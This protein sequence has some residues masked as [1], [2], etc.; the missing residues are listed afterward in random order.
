MSSVPVLELVPVRV[1]VRVR[2]V[3]ALGVVRRC[4]GKG[5]G[6]RVVVDPWRGRFFSRYPRRD[7]AGYGGIWRDMA[8]YREIHAD[9][10]R[11]GAPKMCSRQRP[12][13]VK[14]QIGRIRASTAACRALVD[15]RDSRYTENF[16]L[17]RDQGSVALCGRS[18]E[19]GRAAR[20][21]AG[22]IRRDMAGY[23]GIWRDMAGYGQ[24][25]R[26]TS[27]YRKRIVRLGL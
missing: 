6:V 3:V 17:S 10:M 20:R 12:S 22:R 19:R 24:I 16:R 8:G 1:M 2:R 7:M 18:A 23:G 26:D 13:S 27:R 15:S 4:E 11:Y 14:P 9:M 21:E 5:L 25:W